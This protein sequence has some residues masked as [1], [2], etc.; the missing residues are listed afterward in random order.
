VPVIRCPKC[1]N[2]VEIE[3]DWFGRR[4]ACPACDHQ[5]TPRR[6]MTDEP[7]DRSDR[8]DF[9]D[10]PR[11]T[12][13]RYEPPP[14]KNRGN[15]VLWIVLSLVGVFVVLPCVG[16]VGFVVWGMTAKQSFDGPWADFSVTGSDGGVAVSASF[17]KPPVAR[18]LSDTP[19]GG[20]GSALGFHN[21]DNADSLMDAIFVVGCVDY[22]AGTP[23]PLARGYLELRQQIEGAYM[24]NPLVPPTVETEIDTKVAGYPAKEATYSEA[25]GRYTVRVIHVNDRPPGAPV[26]L[27]VV[28]CGGTNLKDDDKQK[29]LNSVTIGGKAK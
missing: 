5:F 8:D 17:P 2:P 20:S 18:S 22:P 6:S 26:R 29:F 13:S 19:Q 12:R 21:M 27:V 23:N 15:A 7:D 14:R 10:R 3:R 25:D 16:C 4:I 11:R 1:D 9:D 28:A 24:D